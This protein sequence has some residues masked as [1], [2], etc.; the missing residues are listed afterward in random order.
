MVAVINMLEASNVAEYMPQL[1]S[2]MT[3]CEEHGILRE[4]SGD[5]EERC[6]D[7][8]RGCVTEGLSLEEGTSTPETDMYSKVP[9]TPRERCRTNNTA[10][11]PT[12]IHNCYS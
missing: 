4:T 8:G 12:V 7:F 2:L 9:Q 3:G 6:E 1:T 10:T 11:D 5:V